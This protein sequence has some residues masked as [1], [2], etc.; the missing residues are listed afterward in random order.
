MPL[1]CHT[2]YFT[3][4]RLRVEFCVVSDNFI[5]AWVKIQPQALKV[6]NLAYYSLLMFPMLSAYP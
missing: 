6:E 1:K 5:I 2:F 3:I 4:L